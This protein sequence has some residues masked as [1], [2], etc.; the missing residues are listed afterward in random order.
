MEI[1][2]IWKAILLGAVQGASEFLPISSSGHLVIFQQWLGLGKEGE[3]LLAFDVALHFGTLV[4]V[5]YYFREDLRLLIL[6]VLKPGMPV[7]KK[8]EAD[9]A[10]QDARRIALYLILGTLPAIF[11]GLTFK[12]FFE[13]LFADTF[14]ASFCIMITGGLLW[15]TRKFAQGGIGFDRMTQKHSWCI[16]IAQAVA[17]LPGISRSGSTMVAGLFLG[18]RPEV[19]AQFSFLLSIP[20]IAGAVILE[21]PHLMALTWGALLPIL[22]GTLAS[23]FVGYA[24]IRWLLGIIQRG[25]LHYFAWYLW[26]FGAVAFISQI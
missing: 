6:S 3:F 24:S 17:I 26:I 1:I 7:E 2:S 23:F 21:I 16:G 20:A 18:L 14:S 15:W 4:A 19:V 22:F 9:F 11:V 12:S 25:H 8:G 5:L 10:P 13:M